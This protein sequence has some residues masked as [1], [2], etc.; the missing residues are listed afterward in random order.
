MPNS[1]A[2]PDLNC[3]FCCTLWSHTSL[4]GMMKREIILLVCAALEP[5]LVSLSLLWSQRVCINTWLY[6]EGLSE[7][8]L[9]LPQLRTVSES[10]VICTNKAQT[11][12]NTNVVFPLTSCYQTDISCSSPFKCLW[13]FGI[14]LWLDW[15]CWEWISWAHITTVHPHAVTYL[16]K[17]LFPPSACHIIILLNRNHSLNQ[18]ISKSIF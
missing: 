14:S 2:P 15:D 5:E 7:M 12:R 11:L 17:L 9:V 18:K 13:C 4:A 1:A 3:I 8:C 6:R 10:N 16:F